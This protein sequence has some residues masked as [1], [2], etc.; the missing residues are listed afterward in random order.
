MKLSKGEIGPRWETLQKDYREQ[1]SLKPPAGI[2]YHQLVIFS[3]IKGVIKIVAR[4]V[5]KI[6]YIF[7]IFVSNLATPP[8]STIRVFLLLNFCCLIFDA[9]LILL[10][11]P[12]LVFEDPQKYAPI[13]LTVVDT[14]FDWDILDRNRI[15]LY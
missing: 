10:Y 1:S 12:G 11:F 8:P 14:C 3:M 13:N 9:C 15:A 6:V 7:T 2:T 4:M 5:T